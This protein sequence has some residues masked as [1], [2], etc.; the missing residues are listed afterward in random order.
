MKN[1]DDGG[2]GGSNYDGLLSRQ[3]DK[4][5]AELP[6][7]VSSSSAMSLGLHAFRSKHTCA[8]HTCSRVY[9]TGSIYF[10]G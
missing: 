4:P 2:G 3:T 8:C 9:P 1:D 5:L 6:D 10:D 7:T